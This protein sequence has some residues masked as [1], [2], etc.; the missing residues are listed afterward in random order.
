MARNRPYLNGFYQAL[1]EHRYALIV[2]D[3]IWP[4]P[5]DASHLWSEENNNWLEEVGR[6]LLCTYQPTTVEGMDAQ[7]Y[8]PKT[9]AQNCSKP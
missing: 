7:V 2:A 5:E 6:M 9:G 1:R 8:L 4:K 3:S